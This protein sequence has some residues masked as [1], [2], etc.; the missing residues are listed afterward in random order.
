MNAWEYISPII[1]ALI[2]AGVFGAWFQYRI[3]SRVQFKEEFKLLLDERK[4]TISA[5]ENRLREM[6]SRIESLTK[7]KNEL[8]ETIQALETKILLLESSHSSK[9]QK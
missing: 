5:L 6:E 8:K 2:G 9:K 4:D 1:S 3:K 7:E